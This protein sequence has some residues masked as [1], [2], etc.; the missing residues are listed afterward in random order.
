MNFNKILL[1][2]LICFL[3]GMGVTCFLFSLTGTQ[4]KELLNIKLQRDSALTVIDLKEKEDVI[5]ERHIHD[6]EERADFALDTV[7]ENENEKKNISAIT[8]L[9]ADEQIKLL[10]NHL[11]KAGSN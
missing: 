8:A 7:K 3:A 1:I 9:P 6:L 10:S 5:Q 11:S 2:G 4:S